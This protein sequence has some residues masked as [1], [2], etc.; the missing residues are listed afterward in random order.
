MENK[1]D[2][3][4]WLNKETSDEDLMRLK[5]TEDF[6]TLEKIAHYTAQIETPKVDIK[7]ALA[8]LKLKTHKTAKKGKVVQFNFKEFYKYAAAVV[9]L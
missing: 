5:K 7:R 3:L 2:I 4:K 6:K 8:D 1:N 9:V